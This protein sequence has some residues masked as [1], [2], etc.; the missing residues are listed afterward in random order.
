VGRDLGPG[1]PARI[2]PYRLV[3]VL[4]GGGMGRVFLGRSAGGRPVA[5]KVIRADL[6]ADR[7]FRA[8]FAREV[9]AAR[10]VNGLYT[11]LVVDADVDGPVP[12]LATAYV[13]GPSLE[14]AVASQGPLPLPSL[15]VLAAG[16]AEGLGAIHSVGLVHRD[17]KPSNVLLA[18]DGPRVIDFGISRAAEA[19]ALTRTGLVVGSP[20]FMSPEQAT[21]DEVGPPSDMFCLG[22]VL[23]FAATGHGP[24]GTGSTAALIYRIVHGTP[25]LDG[26]PAEI[27]TVAERCLAKDPGKRPTAADILAE[28]GDTELT[29]DW[30]PQTIV[31]E[32]PGREPATP[33]PT[34][35]PAQATVASAR[36]TPAAT[37]ATS[38]PP[39]STVPPPASPV[40]T[41][42]P[43]G[44]PQR[45]RRF[46]RRTWFVI[47]AAVVVVAVAVA[48][49]LTALPSGPANP[50]NT[51]NGKPAL[52]AV[53]SASR[54]GFQDPDG[55]AAD[56]THLWIAN[57][58]GNSVTELNV[59]TGAWMRTLSGGEYGFDKPLAITDDGAHLWVANVGSNSVTELS[60][61]N[62]DFVTT[63]SGAA[64][65]FLSP[66]AI[67]TAGPDIWVANVNGDSL[68]ELRASDGSLVRNVS[69]AKYHFDEPAGL[70]ADGQHIWVAN[71]SL[72]G[73]SG[74]VTELNASDGSLV[75]VI[76]ASS[77]AFRGPVSIAVSDG[78]VWVLNLNGRSVTELDASDGTF[79]RNLTGSAYGFAQPSDVATGGMNVWIVN[80]AGNSVTELNAAS[81]AVVR[82]ITDSGYRLDDPQ[83]ILLDGT[84]AWVTSGGKTSADD[85][86]VTEFSTGS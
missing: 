36:A 12:W 30:L 39:A 27:R 13:P 63:L 53:Y 29:A 19:T 3:S 28:L 61:S 69:G 73:T 64:Y 44:N 84:H 16:L 74:S 51:A 26:V 31:D 2:G 72:L 48:F 4:G 77:Y 38:P 52:V 82:R 59:S 32:L 6:A 85:G 76:S 86:L 9:D 55:I 57:Y 20:G 66:F 24:F 41:A 68:T 7:E 83:S 50:A 42:G 25:M 40:S 78:H 43:A 34:F 62:G 79:V 67:M 33:T 49:T 22:A 37:G 14:D 15:L 46:G 71:E 5:V 21:G 56:G 58:A 60:A 35:V 1:D 11:A 45:G 75:R 23:T 10:R 8:R 81:G 65:G 47:P 70:A 17:L 54:Y 18:D 80:N